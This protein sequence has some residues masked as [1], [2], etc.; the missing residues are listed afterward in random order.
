MRRSSLIFALAMLACTTPRDADRR[1]GSVA[2]IE[3]CTA[4][5]AGATGFDD[6]LDGA[7][8]EGCALAVGTPIPL[9]E[10]HRTASPLLSPWL[11]PDKLRLY[12]VRSDTGEIVVAHRRSRD[13][14]FGAPVLVAR[15]TDVPVVAATLG[16]DELEVIV[17]TPTAALARARRASRDDAFGPLEPITLTVAPPH[18][19]PSISRDGR[20]LF[21]VTGDASGLFVVQRA[22]RSARGEPFGPAELALVSDGTTNQLTP[23]LSDDGRTLFVSMN[24][25]LASADRLASGTFAAP[26]LLGV[27][28]IFPHVD[29]R[30]RELFFVTQGAQW[31]PVP[32]A[33]VWRAP[34]CRD[35]ACAPR[36]IECEGG[37]PSP[38]GQHCYVA[39]RTPLSWDDARADCEARG[40]HLVT[41][42]SAD[43]AAVAIYLQ[44]GA[45][46]WTGG[47]DAREDVPECN[48]SVAPAEG[49]AFAWVDDE[50]W[51]HAPWAIG[52]PS[53]TDALAVG[54]AN[55]A[56]LGADGTIDDRTC[57]TALPFVCES[58]RAISW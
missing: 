24:G 30:T 23:S 55:C 12:L 26:V 54:A 10:V 35:G 1:D 53:N 28:G 19:H 16:S 9:S 33:T 18:H 22:V 50:P 15:W 11:S 42:A 6:D 37:A 27:L 47:F 52:E 2:L 7:I 8:D 31:S 25:A 13:S 56:A 41:L 21:F 51:L 58:E 39:I 44:A 4:Q 49:C 36:T 57:D 20:E 43:E 45:V 48:L 14:R 46:Q 29:V 38:D 3:H 17:S 32:S 40:A 5:G 34:I